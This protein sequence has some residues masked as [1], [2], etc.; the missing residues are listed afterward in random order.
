M[1]GAS[2]F[3]QATRPSY[4]PFLGFAE[5]EIKVPLHLVIDVIVEQGR[6]AD[7]DLF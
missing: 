6:C 1:L 4:I 3:L 7:S 5:K 2:D